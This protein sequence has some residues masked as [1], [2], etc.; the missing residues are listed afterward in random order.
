MGWSTISCGRKKVMGR[1]YGNGIELLQNKRLQKVTERSSDGFREF[2]E[3][4]TFDLIVF[5]FQIMCNE[6]YRGVQ[7]MCG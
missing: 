4:L 3:I 1:I 7:G 2:S 6:N 5:R